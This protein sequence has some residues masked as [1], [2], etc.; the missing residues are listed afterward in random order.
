MAGRNQ[1]PG[2]LPRPFIHKHRAIQPTRKTER[3]FVREI[4]LSGREQGVVRALGFGEAV[5]GEYLLER[6]NL[7]PDDLAD[8][9]SGLLTSGLAESVPS[10]D[11]VT[12]EDL[13]EM[14]F[15]VNPSYAH[16]LKIALGY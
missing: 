8:V 13:P 10:A 11:I 15:E 2:T 4:K 16:Q 3:L 7:A 14:L 5:T 6:T 1:P 9:L 12:Q